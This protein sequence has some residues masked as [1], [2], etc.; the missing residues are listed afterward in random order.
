MN[1]YDTVYDMYTGATGYHQYIYEED[2]NYCK[3]E[4]TDGC[5]ILY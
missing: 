4:N 5:C 3:E 2:Y 1:G